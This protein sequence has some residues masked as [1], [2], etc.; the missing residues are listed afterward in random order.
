[1]YFV[2]IR[3]I[4][5]F[6]NFLK[7]RKYFRL[8][9]SQKITFSVN[10]KDSCFV[11]FC[12]YFQDNIKLSFPLNIFLNIK[13]RLKIASLQAGTFLTR[14]NPLIFSF[15]FRLPVLWC[16]SANTHA[17]T[18]TPPPSSA[19]MSCHKYQNYYQFRCNSLIFFNPAGAFYERAWLLSARAT[20]FYR[21]SPPYKIY[22]LY[23][24]YIIINIVNP[25]AHYFSSKF[26]A[27]TF[28]FFLV[29]N[30]TV[31]FLYFQ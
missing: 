3:S 4:N 25:P 14:K 26:A 28:L 18:H 13:R 12:P 5:S 20:I 2:Y 29:V 22:L 27:G 7:P 30:L 6:F 24:I 15:F 11:F 16:D 31:W 9:G 21:N 23:I 8:L 10:W 17:H 19:T 1:M